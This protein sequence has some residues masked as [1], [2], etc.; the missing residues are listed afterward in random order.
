V[1]YELLNRI[2]IVDVKVEKDKVMVRGDATGAYLPEQGLKNF[3]RDFVFEANGGFT[4]IDTVETTSPAILTLLLHADD[5]V[6]RLS[7]ADFVITSGRVKLKI[8]PAIEAPVG[9]NRFKGV[10]EPN[11]LTAPGPPGA[12]DKGQRQIR[13]QKLL[14]STPAPV[15]RARLTERL[16]I[17]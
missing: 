14:L 8:A 5:K 6:E 3:V 11:D 7:D 9:M 1:S 16:T 13:G 2:R 15:T 12:V 10:I 17:Q 4:I